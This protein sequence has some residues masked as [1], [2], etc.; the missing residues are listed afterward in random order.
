MKL[1]LIVGTYQK[2]G[3]PLVFDSSCALATLPRHF[4]AD[5]HRP[6]K[7]AGLMRILRVE[8]FCCACS[9]AAVNVN[10]RN[11]DNNS[12]SNITSP[13]RKCQ[14]LTL[15]ELTLKQNWSSGRKYG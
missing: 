4:T 8:F 7:S 12:R 1:P 9:S 10:K 6:E 15:N 13:I 14:C 11:E 2:T 5:P 3:L